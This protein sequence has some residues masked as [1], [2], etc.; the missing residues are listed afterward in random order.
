MKIGLNQ[1]L[2]PSNGTKIR[3]FI[4]RKDWGLTKS[5]SDSNNISIGIHFFKVLVQIHYSRF[6]GRGEVKSLK[7][8]VKSL[9]FRADHPKFV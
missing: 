2:Y 5:I 6:P 4:P 8:G 9:T 3:K 7:I 1:V